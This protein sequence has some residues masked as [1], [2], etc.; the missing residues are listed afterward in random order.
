MEKVGKYEF[1]S[2]FKNKSEGDFKQEM[3]SR[4]GVKAT[5]AKRLFKQLHGNGTGII[6]SDSAT[7]EEVGDGNNSLSGDSKEEGNTS[8]TSERE[9]K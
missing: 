1:S 9:A 3:K 8:E 4:F 2:D 7:N 5:E 6:E